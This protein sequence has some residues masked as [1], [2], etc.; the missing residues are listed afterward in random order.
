MMVMMMMIQ[1]TKVGI[2]T[3]CLLQGVMIQM[4]PTAATTE[5][6]TECATAI[7]QVTSCLGY[8][9]GKAPEP[10]KE[11]C[12]AV[13]SMKEKQPVCLCFFIGQAHNGSAQIKS[14]GIQEAKLMQ[15]PSACHL[16]N[17]SI[18]E[19]PKLLG[20]SPSSPA[21]A[22]FMHSNMTSPTGATPTS[23]SPS[24]SS[25]STASTG[26]SSSGFKHDFGSLGAFL[27]VFVTALI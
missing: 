23:S 11:C 8:A 18:T 4:K 26:P 17:A 9:T 22:I 13:S 16:T 2:L 14:L 12:N 5:L 1:T 19:C 20:I 15:L 6:T 21:A 24:S 3:L 27:A 10:T 25:S 7:Q